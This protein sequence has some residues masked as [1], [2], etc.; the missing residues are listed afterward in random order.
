MPAPYDHFSARTRT[1]HHFLEALIS[2]EVWEDTEGVHAHA[3]ESK[4][5]WRPK[6]F[7][8]LVNIVQ[9]N[10]VKLNSISKLESNFSVF[11]LFEI[12]VDLE[13]EVY[14]LLTYLNTY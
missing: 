4:C 12:G 3:G 5:L 14:H 7:I 2:D 8:S 6:L 9:N 13:G 10:L 1:E 11:V